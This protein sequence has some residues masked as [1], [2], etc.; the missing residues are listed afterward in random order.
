MH[1]RH[2]SLVNYRNYVRLELSLPAGL[3]L[4][5][6]QNAQGKS[7][8]LEAIAFLA[9]TRSPRTAADTELINWLAREDPYPYTRLAAEVQ[10]GDRLEQLDI[11]LLPG[12]N[13][14]TFRKQARVNSI[15]RRALD[16]VGILLV[17]LFR[18]EDV[19]LVA[20]SPGQRRR[21][22]DLS[23]CQLDPAYCRAL[24]EYNKALSQRNA[25]LRDLRERE[26]QAAQQ[27]RFWDEKL[28]ET[29]ALVIAR[30]QWLVNA[31]SAEASLRHLDLSGGAERLHIRYL[32]SFDPGQPPS[33]RSNGAASETGVS[34]ATLAPE[35]V[36]AIFAAQL[37]SGRSRDIAAGLTLHG[38]HRDD[39]G[40]FLGDRNLRNFGSRGQQRTAALASKM[41][42]LD[43]MTTAGGVTPLLLL[44][45]VMS[46][47][48]ANR[49]AMLLDA[50]HIVPQAIVTT[51][52]W[53][54]FDHDLLA[55]ALKLHVQDGQLHPAALQSEGMTKR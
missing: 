54:H 8:L 17:V 11:T 4:V 31:L 15:N 44:D 45:D 38:P 6:G 40:F 29:G 3:T 24:S 35:G 14:D 53:R 26:R 20:G 48:D 43:I 47:L 25:L 51:T 13:G 1:L 33:G 41:A 49:R 7:N 36:R 46:E 52:D 23:L 32:P 55:A 37:H 5:Q 2:L 50:L 22:L 16:M 21:Y 28:S 27:L 12:S 42:E 39:I 19:D 34:Y 10:R 30:R 9:T 18:P